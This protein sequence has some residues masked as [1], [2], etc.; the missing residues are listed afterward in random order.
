MVYTEA[1]I[2]VI[3]NYMDKH[4]FIAG[5]VVIILFL[6]FG[7]KFL[8]PNTSKNNLQMIPTPT[9][10]LTVTATPTI[11]SQLETSQ[12]INE[13]KNTK[14]GFSLK[15]PDGFEIKE[16]ADG[17]VNLSKWGSTQKSQ[18]ELFD[19]IAI[20]IVQGRLGVNKDLLSLIKADIEQ[21]NQQL[22]PDYKIIEPVI[23]YVL[24]AIS[25]GYTYTA[26]EPFGNV[27]Y[28]YLPEKLN[29]FLLITSRYPDPKNLGFGVVAN[30][31]IKSITLN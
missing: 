18:T 2:C 30:N 11:S 25:G 23:P 10:T 19:G 1:T 6:V 29:K 22:S 16:S 13:Y 26:S 9:I 31:I 7:A 27:T 24:S 3:F 28:Y 5:I 4:Q 17:S 21:K 14:M 8:F 15:Y 12:K 20:N